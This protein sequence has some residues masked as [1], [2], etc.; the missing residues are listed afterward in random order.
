MVSRFTAV[1]NK[2]IS[3]QVAQARN[4]SIG[5]GDSLFLPLTQG[6]KREQE[7]VSHPECE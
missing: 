3:P 1:T 6:K 2:E 4:M 7:T 5:E